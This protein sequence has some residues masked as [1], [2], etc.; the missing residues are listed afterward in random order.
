MTGSDLFFNEGSD[1]TLLFQFKQPAVFKARMDG[2][3]QSAEKADVGVKRS[4]GKVQGVDYIHLTNPDRSVHV[5]SAYPESNI[6]FRSNSLAAL[7]RVLA[8][9]HGKEAGGRPVKRLGDSSEFAYIRTLMPRGA[10]EEDGFLYLSDPFIRRIVGPELKLTERRRVLCYNHLRMI[11]HASLMHRGETG[12]V[13]ESLEALDQSRCSP[14]LFGAYELVCPDGGKYSL[15]ADG[16][17]GVCSHHGHSHELVPCCE[18]PVA[19]VN[20]EEAD[21]Y[22]AF[23][24]EYNGYWRTFFDPIAVRIKVAPEQYRLET[25]IL[26][27]IDNS[28]YTG[29]ATALGGD[30]EPLDALPVPKRNIF[31]VNFPR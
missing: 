28:I 25:I 6:H 19:K 17:A 8:A 31:S 30:P 4:T 18:H 22:K 26:P 14:G 7:G 3:L 16:T 2:F 29:L 1:L 21:E 9:I 13:P 11:G 15:S 12:K 10:K 27:L 24:E 5:F 23:L 20:G